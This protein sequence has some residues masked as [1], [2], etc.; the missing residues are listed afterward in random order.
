[1][2]PNRFRFTKESVL[3]APAPARNS[4]F[5]WDDKVR[6]LALRVTASGVR[7][8]YVYRKVD[9]KPQQISIG[10]FPD[11]TVDQARRKAEE[12]NAAIALGRDLNGERRARR[13]EQTFGALF[14]WWLETHAQPH[15]KSWREDQDVFRRY[16]QPIADTRLSELRKPQLAAL[17]HELGSE[18]GHRTANKALELVRTVFNRALGDELFAGANPAATIRLFKTPARERRLWPSEMAAFFR[19]LEQ[20]PN[21][22]IRDYV[23]LSLYTG[24]RQANVL[25]MRWQDVRTKDAAWIIPETKGGRTQTLALEPAELEIL[26]RRRKAGADSPWVFPGR[27]GGA[28]GHLVE[29]KSGWRRILASAG[30]SDLRLHDLR[31]SFAS[32][33]IDNQVPFAEVGAALGHSSPAATKIYARMAVDTQRAGK[34]RTHEAMLKAAGREGAGPT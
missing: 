15:R 12:I 18:R 20:E 19:A 25:A 32:F 13:Q 34:R 1:M 16:L 7:T 6:A 23:L 22:D 11:L 17:H 21:E 33:M 26:A 14:A 29:P 3:A 24:A 5:Y 30:I 8:F 27:Q 2:T 9:G 28:K 10:R 4:C 31:R